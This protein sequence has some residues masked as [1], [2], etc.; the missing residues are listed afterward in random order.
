[1]ILSLARGFMQKWD[2]RF[3]AAS[4]ARAGPVDLL[5]C[6]LSFLHG[7]HRQLDR[8]VRSFPSSV[9]RRRDLVGDAGLGSPAALIQVLVPLCS[10]RVTWGMLANRSELR[11]LFC[12]TG[13]VVVPTVPGLG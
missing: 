9:W 5:S 12:K 2:C 6:V 1:M 11:L 3:R 4:K 10:G 13:T 7:A 8:G